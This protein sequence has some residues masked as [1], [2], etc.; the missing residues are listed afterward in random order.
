MFIV[1]VF[2]T[3]QPL[4]IVYEMHA[5]VSVPF[6]ASHYLAGIHPGARLGVG[7]SINAC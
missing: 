1:I 4:K 3:A 7:F 5:L 2:V 6:H